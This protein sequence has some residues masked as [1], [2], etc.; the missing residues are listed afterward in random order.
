MKFSSFLFL[1]Q[2]MMA[3]S[4]APSYTATNK[5]STCLYS[6]SIDPLEQTKKQLQKMSSTSEFDQ[7]EEILYKKLI[8]KPA[9]AL[10]EELKSLRLQTKGRKPDL[11]K[12]L[13]EYYMENN[14]NDDDEE[15]EEEEE[16]MD[17][18]VVTP[19]WN[20]GD[21]ENIQPLRKFAKLPISKTAGYALAKAN[22]LTP[23]PIQESALPLLSKDKESL[24]LH[25]ETGSGKT[26]TY[27]L[28][29]TEKL[30][31]EDESEDV[32][33]GYALILTPTRELAAQVAGIAS[34]LAP[35]GSVRLVSN[36]TNLVRDNYEDRERSEG[37]YG[38]RFDNVVGGRKGTKI[39]VGSAKSVMLSLFGS[40]KL[41]PP[42]S[43]PEAK[44]FMADVS[45][46]VLDEVGK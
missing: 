46:L 34:V 41:I 25:A 36:P 30:W 29:I 12:R 19:E 17:M 2:I 20:E 37:D 16:E 44:K 8:M 5:A 10:K 23:T 21:S 31:R 15:E 42:T 35:P 18:Q 13:V 40:S 33:G 26:L 22:F 38:G 3:E 45:Y 32:E 43:K 28:P 7:D 24:I 6:S 9:S 27:L 1:T 4:F 11:A 39:I 14:Q